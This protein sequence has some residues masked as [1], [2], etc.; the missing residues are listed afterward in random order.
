MPIRIRLYHENNPITASY[1]TCLESLDLN[2]VLWNW[3]YDWGEEHA[4]TETQSGDWINMRMVQKKGKKIDQVK[5]K[6]K[7]ESKKEADV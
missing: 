6:E 4:Q 2:S 1:T 3:T 7:R 5:V